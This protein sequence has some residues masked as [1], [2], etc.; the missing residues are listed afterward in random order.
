MHLLRRRKRRKQCIG[1]SGRIHG[2]GAFQ[3]PFHGLLPIKQPDFHAAALVPF[4]L[5]DMEQIQLCQRMGRRQLFGEYKPYGIIGFAEGKTAQTC[6]DHG[7]YRQGFLLG[8]PLQH[9]A[10]GRA[11]QL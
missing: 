7:A 4:D 2:I 8:K 11:V 6:H 5:R 3:Q 10:A 9:T 1:R